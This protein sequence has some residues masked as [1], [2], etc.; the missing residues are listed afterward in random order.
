MSRATP[1]QMRIITGNPQHRP[2]PE[3]EP[4]PDPALPEPPIELDA[5]ALAEWDRLAPQ[6]FRY[7]L[8][9]HVDRGALAVCCAAYGTWVQA[10]RE[11]K[12]LREEKPDTLGGML[13]TTSN[14][15]RIQH[16]VM[17]VRNTAMREY[18]RVAGEFGLT[19]VSRTRIN[20][21]ILPGNPATPPP[22]RDGTTG[23]A[24]APAQSAGPGGYFT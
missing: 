15:N 5:D 4:R 7:G 12:R 6:L 23:N 9:T 16:P 22:R 18:M 14:G 17:G 19:P 13:D 2:M 21:G 10:E 20:V 3:G 1:T 24:A 11:L 8:L